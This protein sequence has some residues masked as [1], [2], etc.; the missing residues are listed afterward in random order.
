[1]IK[2]PDNQRPNNSDIGAASMVMVALVRG[3]IL[4]VNIPPL[5]ACFKELFLLLSFLNTKIK[6]SCFNIEKR[7]FNLRYNSL[8]LT[9][10]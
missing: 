10:S 9:F 4:G 1:M 6:L 7:G 2:S 3:Y 8:V 5:G